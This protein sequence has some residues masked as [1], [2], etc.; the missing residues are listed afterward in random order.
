[1]VVV[2]VGGAPL[3][4][5]PEP[6]QDDS[7][8]A[9]RTR[10]NAGDAEAQRTLLAQESTSGQSAAYNQV[11]SANPF[12]LILMPWYNGEYERK[13]TERATIGLSGSRLSWGDGSG[14]FYSV[15]AALRYY[16]NGNTFRGFYLGPRIGVFW[17]SQEEDDIGRDENRGPHLGFGFELGHAWLVGSERHLSISIG[18]GATRVLDGAA[19]PVLRLVNIGWAF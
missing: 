15:N 2:L 5:T 17:V 12:G 6:I 18:G 14:G 9:V 1:M 7:I 16:P 11:I 13:A 4:Q 8:K 19:I 10:A 3:A